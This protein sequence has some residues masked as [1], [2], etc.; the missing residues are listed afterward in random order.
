LLLLHAKQ[1]RGF[2][3]SFSKGMPEAGREG[4]KKSRRRA[5]RTPGFGWAGEEP[6]WRLNLTGRFCSV[7]SE[8]IRA[9]ARKPITGTS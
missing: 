5:D 1:F 3:I 9:P 8:P 6:A 7:P 2:D 4:P